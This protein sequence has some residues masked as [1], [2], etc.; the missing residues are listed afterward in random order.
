MTRPTLGNFAATLIHAAG[1]MHL[2]HFKCVGAP[3]SYAKHI[4]LQGF[5]K[6][7]EESADEII[8][9]I[10]SVTWIEDY[11]DISVE[12]AG[13]NMP[14]DVPEEYLTNLRKFIVNVRKTLIPGEEYASLNSLIDDYLN[15]IDSALYKIKRLK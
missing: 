5:Y 14:Y 11:Q 4:A 9:K 7:V 8:E 3:G 10:L 1:W 12:L 15:I 2:A 13:G 6:D